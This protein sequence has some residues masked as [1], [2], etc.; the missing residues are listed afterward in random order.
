MTR[1]LAVV[2]LLVLMVSGNAAD[3]DPRCRVVLGSLDLI[4][5]SDSCASP[6]GVCG[7]GTFRGLLRGPYTSVLTSLVPTA[8]TAQTGVVLITGDTPLQARLGNKTG[9][10]NFKDSGA[11]HTTGDGEFAELFSIVSGTG[12]FTG[13]TGTLFISGTFDFAAGGDGTYHGTICLP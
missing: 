13:A 1:K 7:K 11:F 6:V 10:I 2:G 9:V 4:P 12:D 3:A 8:D 5:V